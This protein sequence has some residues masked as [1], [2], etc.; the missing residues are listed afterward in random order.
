[1]PDLPPAVPPTPTTVRAVWTGGARFEVHGSAGAP[2]VIDGKKVDGP[3][4]VDTM[5][6][7]L[8]ACAGPDVVEI[9]AKRRTPVESLE[10]IVHA[11]RRGSA[12]RR[13]VRAHLKFHIDGA[14]IEAVHAERAIALAVEKYCSVASSLARDFP[15]V[16][17]LVLNGAR[18]DEVAVRV[19]PAEP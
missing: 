3:G 15:I 1:M 2:I 18:R 12:P 9:L 11:R 6:G 10:V 7:A 8:A 4:P 16:T 19:V 17:S 5:L 13:V 14:A